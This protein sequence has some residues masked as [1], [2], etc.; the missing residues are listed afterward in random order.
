[1]FVKV[2]FLSVRCVAVATVVIITWM[3]LRSGSA[4]AVMSIWDKLNHFAAFFVLA[5][6]F[7]T[8][9]Y[10][11]VRSWLLLMGLM[12]YGAFIECAQMTLTYRDASILDILAN[13][14]GV[15]GYIVIKTMAMRM[16]V[17][18]MLVQ[19]CK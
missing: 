8:S 18:K 9:C 19:R 15:G 7:D 17:M 1:M 2:F 4:P 11:R 5:C 13:G 10:W 6:L 16:A 3:A 12:S 14:V